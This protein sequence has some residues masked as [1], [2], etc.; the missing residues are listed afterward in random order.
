MGFYQNGLDKAAAVCFGAATMAFGGLGPPGTNEAGIGLAGLVGF[1]LGRKEKFGPECARVR[2]RI[3][4]KLLAGYRDYIK[5]EGDDWELNADLEAAAH[6]LDETLGDCVIDRK[7]LVAT[8]VTPEGFAAGAV[9]VILEELGKKRP[10]LF[11]AGKSGTLAY[12]Y[13]RDVVR[14]GIEAA[15]DNPDDY[16][17]IEPALMWQMA[18]KLGIIDAAINAARADI[19]QL[20][21]TVERLIE[22]GE[23]R[24]R[25]FGI[26]EG[27]LIAL[28]RK[29]AEGSPDNFDAALAGLER[30]LEVAHAEAER[31]RLPSNVDDAVS[32]V[33]ARMDELNANGQIDEA[34]AAL[35]AELVAMDEEDTRRQAARGR[36]YDKGVAQA[37]LT[38][39]V[40]NAVR[41]VVAGVEMGATD[42]AE[43]F[44]ELLTVGE[45]WYERG[46]RKGLN[47]DLEVAIGVTRMAL[48]YAADRN[49]WALAQNNLGNALWTLGERE[50]GTERLKQAVDAHRAALKEYPRER[51]PLE[52]AVIQNNLGNALRILGQREGGTARLEQAI[53]ACQAALEERTRARMP[54]D[55]A[56]TQNNLANALQSLGERESGTD[57]LEKAID[58]FQAALQEW[59]PERL[60]FEWAMTQNNLGNALRILGQR[61]GDTT[62]LEEAVL[63][64]Q[65]ALREHTRNRTPLE[66]AASHNNLG[67]ALALLGIHE[68]GTARLEHAVAAYR[69][70]LEE[71][72]RERVPLDW[73]M[74][75]S[76]LGN[77]LTALGEREAGTQRLEQAVETYQAAL[78]ERTRE[79][80]P[81]DWAMTQ[82]NLG[83]ALTALG[84]RETGTQRLEQAV[85]AY[86]AALEEYTRKR[87]PLD[88]AMT[89]N[90][91][92]DALR[93][94]GERETGTQRLEHAVEAFHAALEERTR[95]RVPLDWAM[96]KGNLAEATLALMEK[97]RTSDD[98]RAVESHRAEALGYADQALEVF[99]ADQSAHYHALVTDLRKRI[100]DF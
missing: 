55:W 10:D 8:A 80:V 1:V 4:K 89:Q 93:T 14:A 52:W 41:F 32:A 62:R 31:D 91:L 97:A 71:R 77:A 98:E 34:Q 46:R 43:I 78:K 57:R 19:R 53:A 59:T 5:V 3:Q 64:H 21:E 60:P 90:N 92:G 16:R 37:I 94:L 58:A 51:A 22:Q 100:M 66:W 81:L 96:T 6:A 82:N 70:A 11:A 39:S 76:N 13:A 50:S 28:A 18:G 49:E 79:R 56:A 7:R 68:N 20:N 47:F 69:A 67:N 65:A 99:D 54:L 25:E 95:K 33:L 73:A 24:A 72:T 30:A 63:A 23:E 17:Q 12:R 2:A 9:A 84:E 87:V 61:E 88:W 74:T 38:R 36:L 86:Q 40:E 83:N 27:L 35:D 75:Q 26:K 85:D 42:G 45:E 44:A 15:A 48:K 29:Y